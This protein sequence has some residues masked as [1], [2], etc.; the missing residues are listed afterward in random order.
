MAAYPQI[1]IRV[2]AE[3]LRSSTTGAANR[4]TSQEGPKR[5]GGWWS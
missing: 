2:D 3:F 4:M 1:N 5:F